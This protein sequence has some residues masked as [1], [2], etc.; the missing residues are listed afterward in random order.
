MRLI[1]LHIFAFAVLLHEVEEMSSPK[2]F[3]IIIQFNY[4]CIFTFPKLLLILIKFLR[5]SFIDLF[6][7]LWVGF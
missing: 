7:A 2:Q 5:Q 1:Y 4:H 6:D 3:I